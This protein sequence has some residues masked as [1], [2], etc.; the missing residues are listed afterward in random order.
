MGSFVLLIAGAFAAA[1]SE[2]AAPNLLRLERG[3]EFVYS[4][5]YTLTL[6]QP[7]NR[8]SRT[9]YLQHCILVRNAGPRGAEATF[10]TIQRT[11]PQA[12]VSTLP[13]AQLEQAIIEPSGRVNFL[14]AANSV[15]RIPLD[16]PPNLEVAAFVELPKS[17]LT[18]ANNWTTVAENGLPQNWKVDAV[19]DFN[20]CRCVVLSGEQASADW[21]NGTSA[22]WFRQDKVWLDLSAGYAIKIDRVICRREEGG[23]IVTAKSSCELE[24]GVPTPCPGG[25]YSDRLETIKQTILMMGE[26]QQLQLARG[27]LNAAAYDDL[28]VRL[29][30]R[31][32]VQ[33]DTPYR[34]AL[35]TLRRRVEMARKGERPPEPLV[36][37]ALKMPLAPAPPAPLPPPPIITRPEKAVPDFNLT[38]LST[39]QQVPWSRLRGRPVLLFFFKPSSATVPN[40][41]ACAQ[42]MSARLGDQAYVLALATEGAPATILELRKQQRLGI[43]VFTGQDARRLLPVETTPC[44]IILDKS[45]AIRFSALGWGGE[46]PAWIGREMEKV[47]HPAP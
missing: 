19:E 35:A 29:D 32:K 20:H 25:L 11:P 3:Q 30:Q 42:E 14:S 44:T 13:V 28:L 34:E 37:P 40:V 45:G 8:T 5:P 33:A 38:E 31:L 10:L 47:L 27:G 18:G 4:G 22:G 15:P 36:I 39:G 24:A 2:P 46:Y 43:G 12:G 9:L 41:L 26:F 21:K 23:L 1:Q 17:G 6:E 7:G 16:G